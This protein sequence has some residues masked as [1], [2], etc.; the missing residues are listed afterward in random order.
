MLQILI[1]VCSASL[2]PTECKPETAMDVISGPETASP[3]TC[4]LQAQ[5]LMARTTIAG[6]ASGEYLKIRCEPLQ[7]ARTT[8]K[9]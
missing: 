2:S 5:A 9:M 8:Q 6:R 7:P 3:M 4:G 1:L